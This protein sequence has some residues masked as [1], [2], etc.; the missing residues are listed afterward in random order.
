MHNN[1][2]QYDPYLKNL[3]LSIKNIDNLK[4][5]GIAENYKPFN[6]LRKSNPGYVE[7]ACFTGVEEPYLNKHSWKY[8]INPWNFRGVWDLE[9][10]RKRIGFF[11]CSFTFGEGING[12]DTFVELVSSKLNLN[13]FNFGI[14]GSGIERV[15]R[16]FS[17]VTK[18][19]D[20][21]YAVITLP[22]WHRVLHQNDQGSLINLLPG[23]PHQS[24]EE[25]SKKIT[26]FDEDFYIIRA[27]SFINWI[28]DISLEKDI[29]ILFSSWDHPLTYCCKKILPD[30]TIGNFPNID[31]KQARD[32]M[33]PGIKSQK[34]HADQIIKA[35]YD[36]TWI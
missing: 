11:G 34:A 26:S 27:T 22:A 18:V 35:F 36:K 29:K 32:K 23:F 30:N 12:P 4:Y 24:F 9:D 25:L 14:G 17:A 7:I 13:G 15:A 19:I 33:H 6:N 16:T 1:F 10:P 31:N 2:S 8:V 28:Y 21:D 3:P 5:Y 20:L